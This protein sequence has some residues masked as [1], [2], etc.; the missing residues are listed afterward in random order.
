VRKAGEILLDKTFFEICSRV[1]G[2]DFLADLHGKLIE[3]HP[4]HIEQ[5]S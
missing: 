5:N 2:D 1:P 4:D 3:P